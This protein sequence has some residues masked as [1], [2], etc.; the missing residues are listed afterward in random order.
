MAEYTGYPGYPLVEGCV[1]G[2]A[3]RAIFQPSNLKFPFDLLHDRQGSMGLEDEEF[4]KHFLQHLNEVVLPELRKISREFSADESC[5]FVRYYTWHN[6]SSL[7]LVAQ[8]SPNGS[9]GYF[10]LSV[11]LVK[12]DGTYPEEELHP[13]EHEA[14][15]REGRRLADEANQREYDESARRQRATDRENAKDVQ[16]QIA[17]RRG[18]REPVAVGTLLHQGDYLTTEANQG[19][20]DA[21]VLGVIGDEALIEYFMPN[22]RKFLRLIDSTDHNTIKA[23][24]EARLPRKWQRACEIGSP[25]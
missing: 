2:W 22:G 20:R 15:M 5:R 19:T 6:D 24:S 23:V 13:N 3:A 4:G 12:K 1:A 11:S 9:Y 7:V 14:R 25:F 17:I 8:G 21:F 10:Y 18:G 16:A